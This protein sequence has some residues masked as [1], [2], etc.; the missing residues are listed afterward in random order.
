[1]ID[2]RNMALQGVGFTPYSIAVQG[3]LSTRRRADE[4]TATGPDDDPVYDWR[5]GL[6]PAL[7]RTGDRL[8]DLRAHLFE[9]TTEPLQGDTELERQEAKLARTFAV[10]T[11][12]GIVDVPVFKPAIRAIT[13][14]AIADPEKLAAKVAEEVREERRRILL[15]LSE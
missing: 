9:R 5:Y 7:R 13:P 3:V 15:L 4:D 14:E 11:P 10:A 6:H 1:M 8:A 2:V 12:S